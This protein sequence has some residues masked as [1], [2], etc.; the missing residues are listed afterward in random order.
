M[1]VTPSFADSITQ[2]KAELQARRPDLA[3]SDGDVTEADLHAAAS[4]ADAC[5]RFAWQCFRDTFI[6]GASGD[7]LRALVDDHLN[8]QALEAEYASVTLSFTR[9]S[10][11][12]GGTIDA[13]TR[14]GAA[15]EPGGVQVVFTTD[16]PIV[17]AGG[18]NGPFAVNATANVVGSDGNVAAG[19]LNRI[20]DPVFDG[21][22][23][24]TNPAGAGGGNFAE[25]DEELRERAR[26]FWGTLRRGTLAALEYGAKLAPG[27]RI[28]KAVEANLAG[29]V[30]VTVTDADG[31]S[32][33]QMVADA[34][35]ELENWRAAG[36]LVQVL[37]GTP[38]VVDM[39]LSL[40]VRIG[41][42]VAAVASILADAVEARIGKLKGSEP[43]YLDVIVAAVIGQYPDDI[44]DVQFT[45][46]IVGGVEQTTVPDPIVPGAGQVIRAGTII[47][48]AAS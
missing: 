42:D 40:V 26:A 11:G 20:L 30:T 23:V 9:T 46:V 35:A 33:A 47:V 31:N 25:K 8:I 32:T 5:L 28:A 44:L 6:D 15:I 19:K 22:F 27:V 43:L 18:A 48:Q 45:T 14:V 39:T 7:A 24:V 41:L 34:V 12:A 4:M 13:G 36:V 29:L 3:V 38:L 37:G 10:G 2:G 21:T 16:A 17:V 1:P